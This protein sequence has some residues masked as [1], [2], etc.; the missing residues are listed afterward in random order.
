M[1]EAIGLTLGTLGTAEP[2]AKVVLS[3][4]L[5]SL[6]SAQLYQS[7]IKA[8]E[9]L[10]VNSYD[11]DAKNCWVRIDT[12]A[13]VVIDDGTGMDKAGITDLWHIGHSAKRAD[14]Y[15]RARSRTQIGKFG[16]GKLA[17]A[18]IADRVTYITRPTGPDDVVLTTTV[19]YTEFSSNP[20]GG[21]EPV[22]LSVRRLTFQEA[23]AED[24]LRQLVD[25]ALL[26]TEPAAKAKSH[27]ALG[28]GGGGWT[29]VLLEELK[30]E[31]SEL[32][33]GRLN[34]V[35]RTAMPRSVD[36]DLFLN[37]E[38]VLS[39]KADAEEVVSFK[40]QELPE[41]R[42][43][44]IRKATGQ[45]VV[46]GE[47]GL[48]SESYP[49]GIQ[50]QASVTRQSLYGKSDDIERSYGF[51]VRVHGR[52]V[53]LDD[54]LFGI[55]P[56][57]HQIVN[58]FVCDIDADDLDEV[59]TAPREGVESSALRTSFL[60]ILNEIFNEARSRYE[61]WAKENSTPKSKEHSRNYVNPRLVERPVA[62]AI[63]AAAEEAARRAAEQARETPVEDEESTPPSAGDDWFYLSL[64]ADYD[65]SQLTARLYSDTREDSYK[66]ERISLGRTE[67][68]VRFDPTISTF[69]L[70]A[71]HDIVRAHD[72]NAQSQKL[73]E[74]VATAEAMLE[75]YLREQ[76]VDWARVSELLTKRDELLRSLTKDRIYSLRTIAGDL[77]FAAN[78]ENELEV[79]LVVAARAL[80]FR[81][82][83]IGGASDPDGLARLMS[84]PTG[85]IRITLEAKSSSKDVAGLAAIG[86]D[87]LEQHMKDYGATGCLLVAPGY[88][89]GSLG[90]NAAAAKRALEARVSC[91]T[92]EQLASV[93][94][95]SQRRNI[96]AQRVL[97]VIQ[98]TFRPE[99]VTA[100]VARLLSTQTYDSGE[101]YRAIF[102]VLRGLEGQML[103]SPRTSEM[104]LARVTLEQEFTTLEKPDLDRALRA[105]A[106]VS[107]EGLT[108]DT[109]SDRVVLH[110]G[111]D[112]L[113]RRVS[114]MLEEAG[115]PRHA[116]SFTDQSSA[117]GDN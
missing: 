59:L 91:W 49:S 107:H 90:D 65:L 72:D 110:V 78:L 33:L 115:V 42:L 26:I 16:I 106:G 6:L 21:E 61:A 19:D 55:K 54:P 39:S 43:A 4:E 47:M 81:A 22:S 11:A 96:T 7:P 9:E 109:N 93:V 77:R 13:I 86:F 17:T 94:E 36:F 23:F 29:I 38:E 117:E 1:T 112:E 105:L 66:Y 10:V 85:D 87:A 63:L 35:L 76:G 98:T 45:T 27:A 75:V 44:A 46:A 102:R 82:R 79:Q 37:H 101:L 5:V 83:H 32:K 50:G 52:L 99:D 51:F 113:E 73:V 80:G 108:F 48:T 92:V 20:S 15:Q 67:P 28:D 74:D 34:W 14:S 53:N 25:D 56:S 84:Y 60:I 58:R 114:P 31:A 18:A 116:G 68:L 57:S 8:I 97:E 24:R 89:G 111:I 64:P 62:D 12:D 41:A 69:Q 71:D 95:K 30:D 70:N 104:I 40:L 3:R 88:P 2:E 100:A 103:G